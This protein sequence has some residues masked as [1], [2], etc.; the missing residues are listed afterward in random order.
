VTTFVDNDAL[1]RTRVV[2]RGVPTAVKI[3]GGAAP[4]LNGTV[5]WLPGQKKLSKH[6]LRLK[7]RLNRDGTTY[8]ELEL[9]GIVSSKDINKSHYPS[10]MTID[11]MIDKGIEE[12]SIM[13]VGKSYINDMCYTEPVKNLCTQSETF[14]RGVFSD[15]IEST[16]RK[17]RFL[18]NFDSLLDTGVSND[19]AK[20]WIVTNFFHKLEKDFE[21]ARLS[22]SFLLKGIVDGTGYALAGTPW[23]EEDSVKQTLMNRTMYCDRTPLQSDSMSYILA[24]HYEYDYF[25]AETERD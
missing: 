7:G 8:R 21:N 12:K 17:H 25:I 13:S 20:V 16:T 11:A 4:V 6:M 15:P 23:P 14:G 2:G 19:F 9:D 5:E 22:N 24:D 1:A 3:N 10:S 18:R